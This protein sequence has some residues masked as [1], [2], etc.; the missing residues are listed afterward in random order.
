MSQYEC[1]LWEMGDT[2]KMDL[3]ATIVNGYVHICNSVKVNLGTYAQALIV[4]DAAGGA[5]AGATAV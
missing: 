4:S 1:Q 3:V 5:E 2:Q